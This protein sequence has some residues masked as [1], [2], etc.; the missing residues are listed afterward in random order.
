MGIVLAFTG[1]IAR[2]YLVPLVFA[3]WGDAGLNAPALH[4]TQAVLGQ[5]A[6][7]FGLALIAFLIVIRASERFRSPSD[8]GANDL[9]DTGAALFARRI[10]KRLFWVGVA[11]AVLGLVVQESLQQW[12]HDLLGAVDVAGN[13]ARDILWLVGAPFEAVAMPLGV[14]LASGALAVRTLEPEPSAA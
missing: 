13:L 4:W 3:L 10:L 5:V 6:L 11:L 2:L 7:Q 1:L 9:V 14:M 12:Q 8:A